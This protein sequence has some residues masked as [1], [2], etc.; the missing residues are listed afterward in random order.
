MNTVISIMKSALPC[1]VYVNRTRNLGECCVYDYNTTSW[2]GSRRVV[3][4]KTYI[5]ADTMERGLELQD[6]LD[7]ALVPIGDNHLS[8]TATSCVRN[9]GGW[10]MDGDRHIR[11]AYYDIT[12]RA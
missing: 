10:L 8:H 7:R 2:N 6:M 12:L 11:I 3:R 9:G 5:Y 4:M 1:P